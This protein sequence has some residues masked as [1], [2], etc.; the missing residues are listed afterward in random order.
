MCNL[1]SKVNNHLILTQ[2]AE[3]ITRRTQKRN[4]YS[5]PLPLSLSTIVSIAQ[6]TLVLMQFVM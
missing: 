3:I 1:L 5:L 2:T 4:Y 6:T